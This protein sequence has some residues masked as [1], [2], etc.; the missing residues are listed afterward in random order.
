[1]NSQKIV[2]AVNSVEARCHNDKEETV[3]ILLKNH[4]GW[5]KGM[6]RLHCFTFV[7]EI[8]AAIFVNNC[9]LLANT[10][11]QK[12][13]VDAEQALV[14]LLENTNLE[15]EQA[16]TT[17][18]EA[19]ASVEQNE[20]CAKKAVA[21]EGTEESLEESLGDKEDEDSILDEQNL[22]TSKR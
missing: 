3:F 21:E 2:A 10:V 7:D 13:S 1:M 18:R 19:S 9:N 11:S 14:A 5:T 15:E 22:V 17:R 12:E 16:E 8:D 20:D 6:I 4:V